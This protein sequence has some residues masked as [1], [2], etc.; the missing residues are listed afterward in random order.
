M[1]KMLLTMVVFATVILLQAGTVLA[2]KSILDSPSGLSNIGVVE[3]VD[4]GADRI[5]INDTGYTVA[6]YIV[7]RD[8]KQNIISKHKLKPG[9]MVSF[10]IGQVKSGVKPVITEIWIQPSMQ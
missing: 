7:V 2:A 5:I 6:D 1:R 8:S 10:S 4:L 3:A 9:D